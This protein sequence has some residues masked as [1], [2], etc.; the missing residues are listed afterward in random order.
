MALYMYLK[1]VQARMAKIFNDFHFQIFVQMFGFNSW[2]KKQHSLYEKFA[3]NFLVQKKC[4]GWVLFHLTR[5]LI[6]AIGLSQNM[7]V[8]HNYTPS[9][10]KFPV[11]FFVWLPNRIHF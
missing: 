1:A 4:W 6:A 10:T 11:I 8:T 2:P 7:A 9:I 5:P 3:G